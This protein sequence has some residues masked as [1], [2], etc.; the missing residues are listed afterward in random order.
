[1]TAAY[2]ATPEDAPALD[3]DPL[4][5]IVAGDPDPTRAY[6]GSH[7]NAMCHYRDGR[8]LRCTRLP[9]PDNQWQHIAGDEKRVL[10]VWTDV[11]PERG[12]ALRLDVLCEVQAERVRQAGKHGDQ[13]HLPDGTAPDMILA[14]LPTYQGNIHADHLAEWAKARTQAASQNEG[15]DGS[16]TFEHILTE[17]WAEAIAENDPTKL[18]TGLIQ[19][20]AVAVQWVQAIDR[21]M[22]Q[23]SG[24]PDARWPALKA[25]A[26]EGD[27]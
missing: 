24:P 17:E 6:V 13:S 9:H 7:C 27:P 4:R 11:E 21:R 2:H 15:G 18:R 12:D 3:D 5:D 1:M 22:T 23:K 8:I 10:A 19:V 25:T 26:T 20:A 16:I 14:G